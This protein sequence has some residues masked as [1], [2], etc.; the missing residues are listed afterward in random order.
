MADYGPFFWAPMANCGLFLLGL[1]IMKQEASSR[2]W[3]ADP[4]QRLPLPRW[5]KKSLSI[6]AKILP[7]LPGRSG[8]GCWQSES[9]TMTRCPAS[10]PST[11]EGRAGWGWPTEGSLLS[12][13][14]DLLVLLGEV[15]RGEQWCLLDSF[16]FLLSKRD[17]TSQLRER[18]LCQHPGH[19]SFLSQEWLAS[20]SSLCTCVD[21]IV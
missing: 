21:H 8:T 1:G 9:V 18:T 11:G 13:S 15:N 12:L 2:G 14:E 10:A 7:C 20:P 5:S 19:L 16:T 6:N 4:N 3:L 17:R